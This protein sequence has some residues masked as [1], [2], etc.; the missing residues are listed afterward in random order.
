MLG[1]D[2]RTKQTKFAVL[3]D[4]IFYCNRVAINKRC[5]RYTVGRKVMSERG[6]EIVLS[7]GFENVVE[8]FILVWAL[9]SRAW[10]QNLEVDS[11]FGR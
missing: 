7:M 2:Q 3:I 6:T 8:G 4:L 1:I 10:K 11:L 9:P 5:L